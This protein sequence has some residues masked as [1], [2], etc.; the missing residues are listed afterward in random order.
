M[1][2]MC[3]TAFKGIPELPATQL[4]S[5]CYYQM[6]YGCAGLKFATASG[7]G[8]TTAYRIPSSGIGT[9]AQYAMTDMFKNTGGSF[10]GTPSINTTYYTNAT[11]VPAA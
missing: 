11:I 5:Q 9:T 2:Q 4:A 8:V 6:F 3:G 1:F 10:K 7:T